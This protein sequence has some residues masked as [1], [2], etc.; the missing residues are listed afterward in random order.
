MIKDIILL[1]V[2]F[3]PCLM[4]F[5]ESDTLVPNFV[6]IV[7]MILLTIVFRSESGKRFV[8]K[9]FD[10]LLTEKDDKFINE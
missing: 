8:G 4:A 10:K 7:Y 9:M 2:I 3:T 6:G 5:S 1:V